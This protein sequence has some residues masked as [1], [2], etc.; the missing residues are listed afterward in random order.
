MS[1]F[2]KISSIDS[3]FGFTK[4]ILQSLKKSWV[5]SQTNERKQNKI[6]VLKAASIRYNEL[7]DIFKKEYNQAFESKNEE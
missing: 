3:K 7:I 4:W 6:T 2:N 5:R 1:N